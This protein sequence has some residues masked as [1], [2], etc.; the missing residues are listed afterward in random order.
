MLVFH[1]YM[2]DLGRDVVTLCCRGAELERSLAGVPEDRQ[3]REI[4]RHT[5]TQSQFLRLRR[6][7]I[8]LR[9][10]R[11]VKV[12]GKG[13]FGEVSIGCLTLPAKFFS[14]PRVPSLETSY[15]ICVVFCFWPVGGSWHLLPHINFV[16]GASSD[17][18]YDFPFW[19]VSASVYI[20][21]QACQMVD[22][23]LTFVIYTRS[24]LCKRL[25]QGACTQ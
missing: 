13:A 23:I 1:C 17:T 20:P 22:Q 10:F 16:H 19:D 12:I 7:K 4:R 14:M 8:G 15:V 21:A 6:T 18:R 3:M 24:A 25:T 11:T 5:R 2:I 9:D